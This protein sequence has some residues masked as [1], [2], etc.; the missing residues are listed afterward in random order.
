MISDYT[1]TSLHG[2]YALLDLSHSDSLVRA[3]KIRPWVEEQHAVALLALS[4]G[5]TWAIPVTLCSLGLLIVIVPAGAKWCSKSFLM[6]S[7]AL[8]DN[9]SH[10][11]VVPWVDESGARSS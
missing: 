10:A 6:L 7:Q 1:E 11:P 2:R 3:R 4:H 9:S 5:D 8:D